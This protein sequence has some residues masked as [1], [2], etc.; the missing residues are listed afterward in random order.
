MKENSHEVSVDRLKVHAVDRTGRYAR[1]SSN[2]TPMTIPGTAPPPCLLPGPWPLARSPRPNPPAPHRAWRF[3]GFVEKVAAAHP[4]AN[5][6]WSATSVPRITTPR[7]P[8][9]W[10]GRRTAD[11]PA[12]RG[13]QLVVAEPC[14]VNMV[15]LL[16]HHQPGHPPQ[17]LRLGQ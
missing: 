16:G 5:C 12:F 8:T 13:D 4:A 14:P 17:Q 15:L 6:A 10:P 9:G 11:R 3:L 1:A 7:S 2:G